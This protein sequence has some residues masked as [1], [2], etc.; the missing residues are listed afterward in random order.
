M[1][2]IWVLQVSRQDKSVSFIRPI[3]QNQLW[4]RSPI[5]LFTVFPVCV[6]WS[7]NAV[8]SYLHV[9][10]VYFCCISSLLFF[11]S[12]CLFQWKLLDWEVQGGVFFNLQIRRPT[13]LMVLCKLNASSQLNGGLM[14]FALLP[15]WTLN[16]ENVW[17]P[18]LFFPP[19][20][21]FFFPPKAMLCH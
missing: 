15:A 6:L 11:N 13:V 21:A 1:A 8:L 5:H 12:M 16:L 10:S 14:S 4:E 7:M 2:N 9:W 20:Q 19:K 17:A 18:F 3:N